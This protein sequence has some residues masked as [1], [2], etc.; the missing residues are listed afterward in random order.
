MADYSVA[1]PT[2]S[3]Y[4]SAICAVYFSEKGPLYIHNSLLTIDM[5]KAAKIRAEDSHVVG[6]LWLNDIAI[7]AGHVIIHYLVTGTY[8]CLQHKKEE[9]KDEKDFSAEF[10]TA[11]RVYVAADNLPLPA[12]REMAKEE[13][14]RIGNWLSIP[15]LIKV[16]EEAAVPFKAYPGIAAFVESRL[17]SFSQT[18]AMDGGEDHVDETLLALGAPDTLSQVVLRSVLL[19]K[20]SRGLQMESPTY[21]YSWDNPEIEL[22]PTKQAMEWAENISFR[23][24]VAARHEKENLHPQKPKAKQNGENP[25]WGWQRVGEDKAEKGVEELASGRKWNA[26]RWDADDWPALPSVS[27]EVVD[28]H[29]HAPVFSQRWGEVPKAQAFKRHDQCDSST[30]GPQSWTDQLTPGSSQNSPEYGAAVDW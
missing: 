23:N 14:L 3:P 4:A 26:P 22:R 13:I 21:K 7:D 12:L 29:E 28:A 27:E 8:Q 5:F 30:D 11:I 24:A 2:R 9:E 17:L 25:R 16:M 6:K 20:A 19:P 15:A 10:A 1:A 18:A